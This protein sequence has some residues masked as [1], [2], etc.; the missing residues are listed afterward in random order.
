MTRLN[1][2]TVA[3]AVALT[4][5]AKLSMV[6][7]AEAIKF[8]LQGQ[9]YSDSVPH[10]VSHYVDDETDVV[11][12]IM[13]GN[14]V[15]QKVSVEITDDSEH[16]NQMWGKDNLSGELSRASFQTKQAGD[17]IACF[18]NVLSDDVNPDPRYFRNVDVDFDIGSETKDYDAL[19]KAEKL[20]PMEM[21]LRKMEDMVQDIIE[22]MEH[23]QQREERMRNTNESTNARVQWFST[24]TM[25]VLVTLGVWQ[26]FYLKRFFRKKRLID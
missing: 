24:L 12:K 1:V 7:R 18:T 25:V 15:H 2:A 17:I 20:K 23:L 3:M 19:A 11:V 4:L 6:P 16:L 26:I 8:E 9:H 10:C 14:G 22:N 21:E 5:L 13:V